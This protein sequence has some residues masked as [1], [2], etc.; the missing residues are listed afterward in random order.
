MEGEACSLR[1]NGNPKGTIKNMVQCEVAEASCASRR[2]KE[3]VVVERIAGVLVEAGA[4]HRRLQ[5]GR[6]LV[7]SLCHYRKGRASRPARQDGGIEG[8]V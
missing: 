1:R 5:I 8:K 4:S 3:V 7:A 2:V 6:V